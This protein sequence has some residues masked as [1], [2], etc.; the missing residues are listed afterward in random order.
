MVNQF[1]FVFVEQKFDSNVL[2][3]LVDFLIFSWVK[4]MSLSDIS[5]TKPPIFVLSMI[6]WS[7]GGPNYTSPRV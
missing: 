5:M 4:D 3:G 6:I 2:V 1:V 7:Q